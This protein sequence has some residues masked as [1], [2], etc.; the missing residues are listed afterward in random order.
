VTLGAP[1]AFFI[2][3]DA[4]NTGLAT[5][6]QSPSEGSFIDQVGE[7]VRSEP[8]A[9]MSVSGEDNLYLV[10]GGLTNHEEIGK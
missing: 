4:V 9:S 5:T 7:Q 2:I 6:T 3:A 10:Y 1:L 8:K